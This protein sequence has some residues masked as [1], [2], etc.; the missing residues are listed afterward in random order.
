[1]CA[2]K[3]YRT[4]A[5]DDITKQIEEKSALIIKLTD[6]K[7]SGLATKEILAE[8]TA[9]KKELKQCKQKQQYL[10]N[11]AVRQR[12]QR[13]E[14][15]E[16][17][18]K[19]AAE[20]E[21]NAK[22]LKKFTRDQLGRPP[23]ED[24]YPDLHE[25][26][27]ALAS[28]GAGADRRCRTETLNACH[29]LDVLRAALL[30][31]G[32]ILSRQAL[33]LRLIPQRSDNLEGKRHVRTVPV[34]IRKATNNPRKKHVD[35]DFTFANKTFLQDTATLFGPESVFVVSNDDKAKVPPRI[36]AATRQAPLVM[37]LECEFDFPITTL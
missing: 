17:R 12:K 23:V 33:Y 9:A 29:S 34:K 20:S 22:K 16:F 37:H 19:L 8:S 21:Q 10:I 30:K 2:E 31:E 14:K 4:L 3:R 26:I 32:Y 24:T 18:M 15:K 27:V 28:A 6:V 13:M 35:A 7:G 5:Q 1:M 36:T 11:D 25:V